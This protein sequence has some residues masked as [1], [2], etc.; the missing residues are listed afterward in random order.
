LDNVTHGL[1]GMLV[2][3]AVCVWRGET[4]AEVRAAASLL[5][6]LT[7]NLPDIDIVYSWIDGP[8]PLGSLLQHRG[9][10]HTLLLA[11]PMAWLLGVGMWRWLARSRPA[12]FTPDRKQ[13][14]L[15]LALAGPA[16]HL[17]MDYGNNYGVHPFWPV[18]SGW[19]YG[20]SIFIVEPL[21]LAIL[22]PVVARGLTRRWLAAL[23]WLAL[24]AVITI[25][26]F[27]PFVPTA[28][29]LALLGLALAAF[30]VGRLTSE[31]T[32]LVLA[33]GGCLSVALGPLSATD[34]SAG[35]E[36]EPTAPVATLSR[37]NFG[38]VRWRTEYSA[39]LSELSRLRR[40]DCR[41]RAMLRFA[42]VPYFAP[43][44]QIA[45]DLRYDRQPGLDFSDV[46]LSGPA[47]AAP[48]PRFVPGWTEP[49]AE[50]FRP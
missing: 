28:S 43:A 39:D 7:N 21:W 26:W 36:V 5:S 29:R 22:V 16:L 12:A 3:D 41:F 9:H 34:C 8:K 48:C 45:G 27:V 24:A 32:R 19:L 38:G 31:S 6:A 14:L 40:A 18:Y 42:R 35:S 17:L 10:T 23:L 4:R 33:V 15:L 47:S 20:D 2:A 30:T 49:R 11:L 25:C 1:F 37:A 13:W 44:R 46:A 50:L